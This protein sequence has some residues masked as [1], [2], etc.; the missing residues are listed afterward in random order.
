MR[1]LWFLALLVFVICVGCGPAKFTPREPLDITFDK[2][3][4]Y[5]L[6]LSKIPKPSKLKPI[7]VDGRFNE[8]NSPEKATFVVLDTREYA[9]VGALVKLASTYKKLTKEQEV[10][11]NIYIDQINSLKEYL[12]LERAKSKEYRNLWV[13]SEN[14]LRQERYE[15]KMDNLLYKGV[16]G[17]IAVGALVVALI[18]L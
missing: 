7:W 15:H 18:A 5:S 8:V 12:A 4:V 10:L 16:F 9:K 14:A 2:T 13:D 11:V 17:V 1:K 3:P 6:D